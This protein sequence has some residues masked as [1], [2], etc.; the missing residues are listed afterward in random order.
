MCCKQKH[1]CGDPRSLEYNAMFTPSP[2]KMLAHLKDELKTHRKGL[3]FKSSSFLSTSWLIGV[4]NL[5]LLRLLFHAGG[6]TTADFREHPPLSFSFNSAL[7]S[8]VME[9][10]TQLP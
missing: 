2:A 9:H 5:L 4:K 7:I 3:A 1:H 6:F 8:V 10:Q